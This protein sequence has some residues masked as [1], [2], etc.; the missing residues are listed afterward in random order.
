MTAGL[1]EDAQGMHETFVNETSDTHAARGC[2]KF[3][4]NA[5]T[6]AK[7]KHVQRGTGGRRVCDDNGERCG[8]EA[9]WFQLASPRGATTT[10]TISARQ[11]R[12]RQQQQQQQQQQ[13][14]G[15]GVP[16]Q[17]SHT[18]AM[19]NALAWL[20]ARCTISL[21]C[22]CAVGRPGDSRNNPA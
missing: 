6:L 11:T 9:Q 21:V 17:R 5:H 10:T 14:V 4:G 22:R 19:V 3:T 8:G 20:V 15:R 7:V 2:F 18:R 16:V 13:H 1:E 12:Q